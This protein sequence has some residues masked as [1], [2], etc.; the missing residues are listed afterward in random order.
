MTTAI[1]RSERPVLFPPRL[2]RGLRRLGLRALGSAQLA[3]GLALAL[4]LVTYDA[5][6]PSANVASG[7]STSNVLGGGGAWI[8]DW[9]LRG[10]GAAA[11]AAAI[12]PIAWGCRGLKL[13]RTRRTA[14][15]LGALVLVLPCLAM[16]LAALQG[17]ADWPL[18]EGPGGVV[19]T[20]LLQH[21]DLLAGGSAWI[22]H[23]L[24][25][26]LGTVLAAWAFGF[27]LE[28]WAWVGAGVVA[29]GRGLRRL[30]RRVPLP[31]V[32]LP[33]HARRTE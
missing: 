6:D 12:A 23:V 13:K 21:A 4:A 33:G 11:A 5:S 31:P 8:A 15:R 30:A 27:D 24:A 17:I 7:G 22:A 1:M 9:L 20:V 2:R 14:L 29:A 28:D 18:R 19:G 26:A 16:G 3:A 10:F 25:L 32:G